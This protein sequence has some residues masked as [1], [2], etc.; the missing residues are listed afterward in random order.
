MASQ[1]DAE[2]ERD[3][4]SLYEQAQLPIWVSVSDGI[5]QLAG[6][7]SSREMHKAVME[8]AQSVD[9]VLEID[10]SLE[11]EVV[12]PDSAFEAPDEDREFGYADHAS[13]LD[14][15]SD[16]EVDFLARPQE[17]LTDDQALF[18]DA[19]PYSPPT[20][21]VVQRGRKPRELEIIGGFQLSSMDE[22]AVQRDGEAGGEIGEP[23][24]LAESEDVGDEVDWNLNREDEDIKDD[25]IREL[26]ED[27]LTTDL[28][29]EV[30]VT[31]G[32]VFLRG[33]VPSSEDASNAEDVASRV[34]GVVEVRDRTRVSGE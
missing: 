1:L 19:E 25:V 26:R 32:V 18:D 10:A 9:G 34:P 30:S 2:I 27:S 5:V 23:D 15:V 21:P 13:L 20:D 3:I 29:L 28:T 24:W 7:V 16:T 14:Y 31:E 4:R 6:V 11:Y 17:T 12:A 33:I 8:L 22:L